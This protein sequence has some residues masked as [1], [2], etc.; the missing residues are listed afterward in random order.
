MTDVTDV[1]AS[2]RS[3]TRPRAGQQQ[4]D[5]E[6]TPPR[7]GSA[8]FAPTV[9][10][11]LGTR[12]LE[13]ARL[14]A[15]AA[16]LGRRVLRLPSLEP[17]LLGSAGPYD[18]PV[19]PAPLR[20]EDGVLA[21]LAEALADVKVA[22]LLLTVGPGGPAGTAR[23]LPWADRLGLPLVVVSD[24]DAADLEARVLTD[25]LDRRGAALAWA[26]RVHRGFEHIVRVA[27]GLQ[28]VADELVRLL[29]A[30]VFVTAGDGKVL[31]SSGAPR[32][33]SAGRTTT[34]FDS[35]GCCL[36]ARQPPGVH[37]RPDGSGSHAVVAV[38]IGLEDEARIVAVRE[39]GGFA[40]EELQALERAATVV[41]LCLARRRAAAEVEARHQGDALRE[42][43]DGTCSAERL[44]WAGAEFGW[45]LARPLAVVVSEL[46]PPAGRDAD[47]EGLLEPF[48]RAWSAAVR[49]RDIGAA[50]ARLG[51][52]VVGLVGASGDVG[53]LVRAAAAA[54][55]S[56]HPGK[57][58]VTLSTGVSR[59]VAGLAQLP[60]AHEQARRAVTVGRQVHG[61]GAVTDF[62]GLGVYRL[63]SLVPDG[64]EL[65]GFVRETLGELVTRDD[66]EM[67]D[68][69][70]TLEVLLE[71][72]L[73]V[74]ETARRLHFHYNTLR[75]RIT[76][77]ERMLGPFTD[78]AHVRLNL[79]L[80]LQA[81]RMRDGSGG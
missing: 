34:L 81:V 52:R 19:V 51:P 65:A 42:L 37:P 54:V 12:A 27:G 61:P 67:R 6:P 8:A 64:G 5:A 55:R 46:D 38:V 28:D 21:G 24:S 15:G 22:G 59:P 13:R 66:P 23:L 74:A 56:A 31:A 2:V 17:E 1:T 10:D 63:L 18:L 29:R 58:H 48:A 35:Q 72:N 68:L 40:P 36:A 43:L 32:L 60:E 49:A 77:L 25:L 62:D 57:P 79:L 3:V 80:A 70:Q 78:D 7:A 73:N 20:G 47:Q 76:K 11:V 26:E 45:N 33:L 71:T 9:H 53:A 39:L 44:T 14:L 75:Y 4:Y 16:G 30:A 50:V 69:R 41:A